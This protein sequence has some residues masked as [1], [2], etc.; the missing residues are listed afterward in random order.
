MLPPPEARSC[1][2]RGC[3]L[4]ISP[5]GDEADKAESLSDPSRTL[6]LDLKEAQLREKLP[7]T[8]AEPRVR[9]PKG[10]YVAKCPAL[11]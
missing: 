5:P 7:C 2:G 9:D 11:D 10:A 4:H 8:A 3:A 1:T 6:Q